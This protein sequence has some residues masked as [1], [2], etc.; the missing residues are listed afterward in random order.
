MDVSGDFEFYDFDDKDGV[1]SFVMIRTLLE[2][3]YPRYIKDKIWSEIVID[4]FCSD[5]MGMFKKL[6]YMCQLEIWSCRGD[7]NFPI[8]NS[9]LKK[10]LMS[11]LTRELTQELREGISLGEIPRTVKEQTP[12]ECI[13]AIQQTVL[14]VTQKYC[15]AHSITKLEK[16]PC[17]KCSS[18]FHRAKKCKLGNGNNNNY[19]YN[20]SNHIIDNR[21]IKD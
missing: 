14:R 7:D 3:T 12:E 19:N 6:S 17:F 5:T 15:D 9:F 4:E 16:R 10:K 18:L 1:E 8:T 2:N 20:N 13:R 11:C 21:N